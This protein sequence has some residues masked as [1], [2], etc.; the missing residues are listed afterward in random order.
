MFAASAG[1][2]QRP[3]PSLA[4]P[5]TYSVLP[6]AHFVAELVISELQYATAGPP[7]WTFPLG[8][9][10]SILNFPLLE[11]EMQSTAASETTRMTATLDPLGAWNDMAEIHSALPLLPTLPLFSAFLP[12][13]S[14]A[15]LPLHHTTPPRPAFLLPF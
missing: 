10:L 5:A 12:P 1:A 13:E 4:P 7:R 3:N 9:N 6:K 11:L 15:P 14:P 8:H 2:L